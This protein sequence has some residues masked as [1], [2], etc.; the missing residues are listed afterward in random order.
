MINQYLSHEGFQYLL[1]PIIF[2]TAFFI[3]RT[4]K[5]NHQL[6]DRLT[7]KFYFGYEEILPQLT[8]EDI[9][10]L[11]QT[12]KNTLSNC[13]VPKVPEQKRVQRK[14]KSVCFCHDAK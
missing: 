4:R 8:K 5:S 2:V 12:F 1:V 13:Q 10:L 6:E 9:N 3:N 7:K 11:Q 14:H